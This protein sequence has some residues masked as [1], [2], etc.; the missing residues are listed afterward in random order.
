[1]ARLTGLI[2][3]EKIDLIH[4]HIFTSNLWGRIAAWLTGVPVVTTEHNVD[5][6]KKPYHFWMDRTLA[7][8][9]SKVICV[10]R[11]VEEFY[12][13]KVPALRSRTTVIYNGI[14][15]DFF[16]PDGKRDAARD[17]LGVPRERFL[18]GTVGRL[19]PQKRQQDFIEA[20]WKLKK[21]EKNIGGILIGDGPERSKLEE[22]ARALGLEREIIFAGFCDDTPAL[23]AALDAFVLCSD[24]EGF[25]MTVLEAMAA[26]V[27]V[28]ATDVGGVSE[29]VE[30]EKTGLLIPAGD[31]DALA[32]ELLR[33]AEDPEFRKH[34]TERAGERV[35]R[36]FSIRKMAERHEEI[37][38]EVLRNKK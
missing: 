31:P 6:W 24:R 20:V 13:Q 18:S 8:I 15:A 28:V 9:G 1:M 25:P 4:A 30:N 12:L 17:R 32:R 21:S 26:G 36:E 11:K 19:V 22:K 29:C 7:G 16:K 27:P 10:S 33:L 37:Y 38:G 14:D 3:R 35:R 2:R 23:Y 5:L 34:L